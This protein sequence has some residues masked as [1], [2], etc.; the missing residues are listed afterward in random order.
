MVPQNI[1]K[2][3]KY[4]PEPLTPAGNRKVEM[5]IGNSGNGNRNG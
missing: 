3:L 4:M 2:R 5:E 1:N